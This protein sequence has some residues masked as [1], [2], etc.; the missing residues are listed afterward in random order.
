MSKEIFLLSLSFF[1]QFHLLSPNTAVDRQMKAIKAPNRFKRRFRLFL[2]NFATFTAFASASF[3]QTTIAAMDLVV[4]VAMVVLV[5][6]FSS[7]LVALCYICCLHFKTKSAE[8]DRKPILS[9]WSSSAAFA[10][11][12]PNAYR[13]YHHY[14]HLQS[15]SYRVHHNGNVPN[16]FNAL[17][18]NVTDNRVS[19]SKGDVELEDVLVLSPIIEKA[20]KD[21]E[22]ASDNGGLI[23]Q[24]LSILRTCHT[25]CDKLSSIAL[26]PCNRFDQDVIEEVRVATKR[27]MP[28]VDDLVQTMCRPSS[29]RQIHASL[30]EA[31]AAALVLSVNSLALVFR[32]ACRRVNGAF[33]VEESAN[34]GTSNGEVCDNHLSWTINW[35]NSLFNDLEFRLAELRRI[36]DSQP[37]SSSSITEEKSASSD[38]SSSNDTG[39]SDDAHISACCISHRILKY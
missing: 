1:T 7:A 5:I 34:G 6:V 3:T 29:S 35:I 28:R 16:S 20:L 8:W 17:F 21:H 37:P 19:E 18:N 12:T 32:A 9:D 26:N 23:E 30:L 31:R 13:N 14:N 24:S 2:E 33:A 11:A 27:V 36:A 22:W 15:E 4:S 25:I 10:S 38:K 39:E